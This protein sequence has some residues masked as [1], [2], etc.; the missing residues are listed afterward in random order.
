MIFIIPATI[1][2]FAPNNGIQLYS[3][4][5][6]GKS[7]PVPEIIQGMKV[8]QVFKA[9]GEKLNKIMVQLATFNRE[10]TSQLTFSIKE[11][12]SGE[13][14]KIIFSKNIN[15]REI[16]DNLYYDIKL[17]G[18]SV[19]PEKYYYFYF[20]S[21]DAVAGNAFTIWHSS[22]QNSN[23]DTFALINGVKQNYNL[24]FM[25]YGNLPNK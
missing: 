12:G 20:E 13:E 11:Y 14:Q 9:K 25:I 4:E 21:F 17:N 22:P 3:T 24:N 15:S 18:I 6:P 2:L 10:N 1:V 5:I 7:V 16:K 19:S 23:E 8:G